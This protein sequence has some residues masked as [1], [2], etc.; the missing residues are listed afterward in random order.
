MEK[1]LTR[2]KSE[3]LYDKIMNE[4]QKFCWLG[5]RDT[6]EG[7]AKQKA[8]VKKINKHPE[9]LRV[10]MKEWYNKTIGIY[11]AE[12]RVFHVTVRVLEDVNACML[13]DDNNTNTY[14]TIKKDH[15]ICTQVV[16]SREYRGLVGRLEKE[17]NMDTTTN[18]EYEGMSEYDSIVE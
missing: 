9:V 1:E 7:I 4:M 6:A 3:K 11:A 14:D 2:E 18:D 8:I 17:L 12:N 10:R 15:D 5:V 13:K 16:N